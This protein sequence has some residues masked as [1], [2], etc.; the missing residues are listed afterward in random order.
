[1]KCVHLALIGANYLGPV[2]LL[3]TRTGVVEILS[4]FYPY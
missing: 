1:M 3:T 2:E 4:P